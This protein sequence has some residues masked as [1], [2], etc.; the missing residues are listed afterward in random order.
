VGVLGEGSAIAVLVAMFGWAAFGWST[1][2]DRRPTH[3]NLH[4]EVD[5]YGGRFEG[6]LVLP[7][8]A[9][10]LYLLL[11]FLP[12]IDPGRLN[13]AN[14]AGAYAVIRSVVVAFLGAGYLLV[15][16]LARGG[17]VDLL[18][19][20]PF[21]LGVLLLVL[22][23]L[24]GKL[25]PNWFVGIRTPWTLSS[26]ESWNRTHR[27]GGWVFV[28]LGFATM[29]VALVAGRAALP[30]AVGLLLLATVALAIYSYV[31]WRDDPDKVPPAGRSAA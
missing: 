5:R 22:G 12:R 15:Q 17:R 7:L 27:A 9:L 13:Y 30:I 25:R 19:L 21:G 26:A 31:V 3:W 1:A 24:M 29:G 11:L 16:T 23:N 10:A 6:M 8:I 28:A 18:N 14:M 4:G 2:S 20:L